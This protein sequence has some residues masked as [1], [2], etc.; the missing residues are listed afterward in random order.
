MGGREAEKG[1]DLG[2]GQFVPESETE[3]T[4]FLGA[5]G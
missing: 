2:E 1:S 5:Q 4:F 3:D